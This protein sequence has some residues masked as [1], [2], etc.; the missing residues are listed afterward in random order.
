MGCTFDS[1]WLKIGLAKFCPIKYLDVY[2]IRFSLEKILPGLTLASASQMC[3]PRLEYIEEE[4]LTN[5]GHSSGNTVPGP[6]LALHRH[7]LRS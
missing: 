5:A 3:N 1:G 7:I 2:L 4:M 6:F